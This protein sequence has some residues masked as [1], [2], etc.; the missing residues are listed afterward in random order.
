MPR[1]FEIPAFYRSPILSVIKNS[2]KTQDR[3]RK[4]ISPSVLD[5][6]TIR[7]KLARHFGF[8]YG[9]ENAIE[10]AYRA[11][12]ENPGQ[13]IYLL[14]EMIHNPH[15]NQDLQARGVRFLMKTDG[16]QL[17]PFDSLKPNDVVIVPAFG[18]TVEMFKRLADIGI[19]PQ[20]YN[21]TC[22]FVEK[23]WNRSEQMGSQGYT[24]I[25]HGFDNHE[26]TRATFSHARQT[27]PSVMIRN[28]QEAHELAVFIRGE[29]PATDFYDAF[30]GR[31]S[32]GFN[33]EADL[34]RIGVVNQTTMLATETQAISEY[35][36]DAVSARF[37]AANLSHHFADTRD[38]LCYATS[39]NQDAVYGLLDSGGDLAIVVGGYNS[40]NT[41][42]LVE[43]CE[44]RLPTF[45]I[46]DADEILSRDS[47]RHL[48][49]EHASVITTNGWLKKN[50]EQPGP[51]EILVTAGA[52][53]PDATVD[54]I[55]QKLAGL[56]N[57]SDRI[58]EA[59]RVFA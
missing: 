11:I 6:G 58:E 19:N 43:L 21:T 32:T 3:L 44:E 12:E 13:A 1:Q 39:E 46:R 16:S 40:S 55:I 7:F 20:T 31:F 9:V 17:I 33:A 59:L 50:S 41:S 10:I 23:V 45:Y 53:C 14:S 48:D 18:T 27:A 24:V 4:D 51:I 26:E 37:G 36:R 5:L 25:I 54:A 29:R 8:C 57:V 56:A 35:L 30:P 22:P 49:M 28:M 38:T 15:V 47:I 42:H 52:S 34:Q 2:R